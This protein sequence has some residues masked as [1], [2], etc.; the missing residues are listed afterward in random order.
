MMSKTL[1]K[2]DLIDA[3]AKKTGTPKTKCGEILNVLLDEIQTNVAKGNSV[4][5]TGFGIFSPR[6][7]AAR[8]GRNPG[9]GESLKIK[10]SVSPAFKPGASFKAAVAK[11]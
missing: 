8:T 1:G 5:I 9:T 11:K 10:A 3:L 4:G 2:T 6:K 7:R